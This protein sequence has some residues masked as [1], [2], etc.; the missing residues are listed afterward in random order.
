MGLWQP[1]LNAYALLRG[2]DADTVDLFQQL[3]YL[4]PVPTPP[5]GS[6]QGGSGGKDGQLIRFQGHHQRRGHELIRFSVAAGSP[7]PLCCPPCLS[8]LNVCLLKELPNLFPPVCSLAYSYD[9]DSL[10]L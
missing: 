1:D 2:A 6:N 3:A 7:S 9:V 10:L 8:P 5:S 4:F